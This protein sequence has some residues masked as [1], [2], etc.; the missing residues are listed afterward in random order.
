MKGIEGFGITTD[1]IKR[2][3]ENSKSNRLTNDKLRDEGV[4]FVSE[5]IE[6]AREFDRE[7]RDDFYNTVIRG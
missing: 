2:H 1:D 7:Y 3:Q 6:A 5:L 4:S